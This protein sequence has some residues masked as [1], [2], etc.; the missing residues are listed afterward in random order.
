MTDA[1]EQMKIKRQ[2][3]E[4]YWKRPEVYELIKDALELSSDE[5]EDFMKQVFPIL[6]KYMN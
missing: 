6:K 4:L 5:Y 2:L 3:E 1:R